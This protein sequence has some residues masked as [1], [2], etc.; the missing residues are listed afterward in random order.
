MEKKITFAHDGVSAWS[1]VVDRNADEVV[2]YSAEQLVRYFYK[3][4]GAV[5]PYYANLCARRGP[6]IH[7]GCDCRG[8]G[9]DNE[10]PQ[11]QKE[12]FTIR[13]REN[14][15]LIASPSS[16][17]VLYG[18]CTFLEKFFGCRWYT[19]DVVKTPYNPE[20]TLPLC[21]F[22][23]NPA[24]ECR[25]IYWRDAF[26]GVFASHNKINS[27]KAD[28]S[29]K[30]G[31]MEKFF[32]F[33][34]AF[35]DLVP[36]GAYFTAHPE[37]FSERDGVRTRDQLCLSN[38]NVVQIAAAQVMRWIEENPD[39]NIF[40]IAQNDNYGYC[41]CPECRAFD[42]AHGDT[43]AASVIRFS[44]A[45]AEIVA[46]KYPHVLLHTFAYQYSRHA[47]TGMTVHP[48]VIVRLCDI[49]C[50]F[51]KPLAAYA[52]D[53]DCTEA[54]FLTDLTDWSAL[55]EHL[56]IWDYCTNFSHYLL[57]FPN[58]A[59]M[60]ENVRLFRDHGVL[61]IFTEGNFSHGGGGYMAELQ[62]YVQAKLFWN[63]DI[64]LWETVDDF[65]AGY[66]GKGAPYIRR[67]IDLWQSAVV[68]CDMHIYDSPASPYITD[69]R[70]DE[71]ERLFDLASTAA[72]NEAVRERIERARLSVTYTKLVRMPLGAP[73]RD[74]LID[75]FGRL[76]K[77]HG[78]TEI[79][80]RAYLDWSLQMMKKSR[81]NTDRTG[82]FHVYYRM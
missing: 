28:I 14:G 11:M 74:T 4:T 7:L 8:D 30:Q 55:T 62:A 56:Y 40:S 49:E 21:E 38:P 32:N 12:G 26:D 15:I 43:P 25:D 39:C 42:E 17:G 34:H 52:G 45:V 71:S 27:G 6:E 81:H 64:D 77:K 44:N 31:G 73:N 76:C 72:E 46:Q 19:A 22:T 63:P 18:V 67:Y 16:R 58:L 1:I 51:S 79:S 59:S 23:E 53:P 37:Y 68:G 36:A 57:M 50:S 47:P 66:F 3:C 54:K 60:Q 75:G 24:F 20:V 61:G 69:E 5:V 10:L 70:L 80:E 82:K 78:L 33:H 65:L 41:T 2:R 29:F 48:N 9:L 13:V 35:L